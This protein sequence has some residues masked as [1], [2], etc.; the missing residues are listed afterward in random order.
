M[1]KADLLAAVERRE[2]KEYHP[3]SIGFQ[4]Q[5]EN[6]GISKNLPGGQSDILLCLL[7]ATTY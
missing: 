1:T 5:L 7:P 6:C 2:R 4:L 3:D